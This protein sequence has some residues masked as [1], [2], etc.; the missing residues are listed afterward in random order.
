MPI[1][2]PEFDTRP[3]VAASATARL[4]ICGIICIVQ[5]WLLTA[6]MEAYHG[7]NLRIALPAFLAS[8]FC[9]LLTAGLILTG[10]AGSRKLEDDVRKK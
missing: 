4:W 9:F 3:G 7:G 8:A 6:S 1:G 10:E 5:Y 2:K